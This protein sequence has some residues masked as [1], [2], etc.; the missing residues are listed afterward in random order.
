MSNA[1]QVTLKVRIE[2][3]DV[4]TVIN[5]FLKSFDYE[6]AVS[7]EADK[8]SITLQ[9]VEELWIGDWFPQKG[10]KAEV[11]IITNNWYSGEGKS[12]C[13][14]GSF[15][16][17]EIVNSLP[18]AICK[19]KLNSI[20]NNAE[21]RNINRSRSWEK[22]RLSQIAKDVADSAQMELFYDTKEDPIIER[23]EQSEKSDLQF[24]RKLCTDKGLALKVTDNKIAIFDFEK[25]ESQ[26]PVQ[27]YIKGES[28][29]IKF[30]ATSKLNQVYKACQVTYKHGKKKEK[31]EATYR[32]ES[33]SEGTTLKINQKVES[34]E[35]AERL[36][37]K[38]LRE[39]NKE[40]NKLSVTVVGDIDLSAGL[41]IEIKGFHV[42]DG[43]YLINKLK[44]SIGGS[45]GFTSSLELTKCLQG[46]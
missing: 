21:I 20:P 41:T 42:H 36:A 15:E 44:H 18:P 27:T 45:G 2:T 30:E 35:E 12:E 24:L 25:Y 6:E 19:L 43:K 3:K 16:L 46:Y 38:K 1:R 5:E 23:A 10:T 7:D 31:I 13:P 29:I 26:S 37:K 14:L 11:S 34:K 9:D 17:D 39:K 8:A 4:S 28:R 22:T 32:D 33:K 40:E